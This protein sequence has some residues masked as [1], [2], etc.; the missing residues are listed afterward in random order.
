[1]GQP[2][3][4][5]PHMGVRIFRPVA[6]TYVSPQRFHEYNKKGERAYIERPGRYL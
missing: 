3:R 1:M 5:A 2:G 4:H 6:M